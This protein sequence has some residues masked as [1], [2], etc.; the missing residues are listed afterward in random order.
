MRGRHGEA[1]H[2]ARRLLVLATLAG[3][4]PEILSPSDQTPVDTDPLDVTPEPLSRVRVS[5]TPDPVALPV[6]TTIELRCADEL[7]FGTDDVLLGDTTVDRVVPAGTTCTV[8]VTD[9]FGGRLP[10]GEVFV[11][12]QRVGGWPGDRALAIEP[13]RFTTTACRRGCV[14]PVAVDYD[15]AANIDDGTCTYV[16]GCTDPTAPEYDATATRDDGSCTLG[17]GAVWVV[18]QA[19]D[20]AGAVVVKVVCDGVPVGAFTTDTT[21]SSTEHRAFVSPG[22]TCEAR[23]EHAGGNIVPSVWVRTC[24]REVLESPAKVTRDWVADLVTPFRSLRC[25]GCTDP[26]AINFDLEASVDDGSCTFELP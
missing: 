26:R 18:T 11:C 17:L 22:R 20:T 6:A 7:L 25:A 5:W 24:D 8:Q 10:V 9:D 3:C 1:A 4:W 2:G 23:V 15:P 19:Y 13:I 21:W 14:D 12:D 16:Y